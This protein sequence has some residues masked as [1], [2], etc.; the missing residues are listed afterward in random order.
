MMRV[1]ALGSM[2]E[3]PVTTGDLCFNSL[4]G[5][6]VIYVRPVTPDAGTSEGIVAVIH[7][8]DGLVTM[9]SYRAGLF[10]RQA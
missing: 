7:P 5:Q 8:C 6:Q 9:P 4:D 1:S 3:Q 10:V 2:G